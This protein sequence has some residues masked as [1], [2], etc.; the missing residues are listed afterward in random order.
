MKK[1]KDNQQ[2]H[3]STSHHR[4]WWQSAI[5]GY[6]FA[7]L[8]VAGAFS[9]PLLEKYMRIRDYFIAPPFV[10]A[11]LLVGWIWGTGPALLALSAAVFS[12]DYWIVPPLGRLTFFQWPDI[13]S[14]AP[15]ILI[16]LIVLYLIAK[17]KKYRRQLFLAQQE[18]LER[19][20]ELA[21]TNQALAQSNAQLKHADQVKDQFLSRASH[22]LKTPITTIRGQAQLALR[23]L[24]HRSPL[25]ADLAF[26]PTHLEKVEAQTERLHTL[27]N[28]LLAL[29]TLRSGQMPLRAALCDLCQLCSGIAA[30]QGEL[31]GRQIDLKLARCPIM[32]WADEGRLSQVIINLIGNALKYSPENTVVRVEVKQQ[33]QQAILSV[34]NDGPPLPQAQH[35]SIFEPFYRAPGAQSS[36]VQGWGLGLSIS[37]EI[38]E[39]HQGH[40][41]IESSKKMGTT[42]FVSLPTTRIF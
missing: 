36:S 19:A 4:S 20:E 1:A 21:K 17:Q 28:D 41:W 13:A 2:V 29:S 38:I 9:L 42:F 5:A 22:E 33:Q 37:K 23:R 12:V 14:F 32:L 25:C 30:D 16:Q 15:F 24:S 11:T 6:P 10:V 7:L 18:A 40:I 35:E 26:L 3:Q 34:H 27:V 39:Q 31:T 8:F